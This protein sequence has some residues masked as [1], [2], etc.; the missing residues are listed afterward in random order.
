MVS[1]PMFDVNTISGSNTDGIDRQ[2]I[3]LDFHLRGITDFDQRH[4]RVDHRGV[5]VQDVQHAPGDR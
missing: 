2:D 4:S 3:D 5:F 1:A